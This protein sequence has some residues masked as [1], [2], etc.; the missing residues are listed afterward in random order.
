M[1]ALQTFSS[2]WSIYLILILH[3]RA[4]LKYLNSIREVVCLAAAS[5]PAYVYSVGSSLILVDVDIDGRRPD[6][7]RAWPRVVVSDR[8][9]VQAL[10]THVRH[11]HVYFSDTDSGAIYRTQRDEWRVSELTV[12]QPHVEGWLY[13]VLTSSHLTSLLL[14]QGRF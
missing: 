7:I 11:A 8:G 2:F 14:S 1:L 10:G 5:D 6:H 12:Q 3:V 9:R 13:A 4:T